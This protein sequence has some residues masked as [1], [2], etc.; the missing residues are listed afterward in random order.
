MIWIYC[1][2]CCDANV[3]I[4]IGKIIYPRCH[5]NFIVILGKKCFYDDYIF[6]LIRL[7]DFLILTNI[8][9]DV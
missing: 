9:R 5:L 2:F 6:C 1:L 3:S 7:D 8:T 4:L